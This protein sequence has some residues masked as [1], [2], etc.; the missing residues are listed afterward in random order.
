[1]SEDVTRLKELL[2][3]SESRA[4]ADL[5]RRMDVVFERAGSPERFTASV[6]VV[7]DEALLA[8]R[9]RAAH[10]G[11]Q[12]IAPLI[13]KT[14]KTEIRSSQDELAEALYPSLG[15]MVKAYVV[16]AVRDL[17]DEINRRLESNRFMLRVRSILTGRPVAELAF[18]EGQ[19]LKAE[20]LYLIRRGLG[21]AHRALAAAR[22]PST[23]DQRVSGILTA[24]NEVATE[25]FDARQGRAAAHRS[26]L[27]ARLPQGLAAHL[28]A[29]KCRGVAPPTVEQIIDAHFLATIERLRTLLNGGIERTACRTERST[30]CSPSLPPAS[31]PPSPSSMPS[32]WR[33]RTVVS[34]RQWSLVWASAWHWQRGRPGA[35]TPA[36]RRRRCAALLPSVLAKETALAGYPVHAAVE[37]RGRDVALSGLVPTAEAGQRAP[38]A[39][40]ARRCPAREI[41]DRTTALPSGLD[42]ARADIAA[43]QAELA[44][45]RTESADADRR[46][47]GARGRSRGAR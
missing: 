32:S 35:P 29:A 9:D 23:Q 33:R 14:I 46:P 26:R 30:T 19:R 8:S 38:C 16:S 28:L 31:M 39:T 47:A 17:M 40:C 22:P 18:A 7:L 24:I 41:A 11:R 1:M 44:R 13:V 3:E 45:A 27:L 43:L 34:A 6:A 25:A 2:F 5:G 20:E 37:R 21:R 36:I 15:R 12:A 42:E 4:L 10:R